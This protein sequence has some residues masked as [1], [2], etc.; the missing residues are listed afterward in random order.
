MLPASG[1]RL[2]S[3]GHEPRRLRAREHFLDT[4][5]YGY[6]QCDGYGAYASFVKSREE[7]I[8]LA[9][10]LAHARR[11]FFEAKEQAPQIAGF[12]LRQMQS[13]YA[14]EKELRESRA[15]PQ[16]R[17]AI[18]A[19]RS[20]PIMERLHRLAVRLE[21]KRRFLPAS[22]MG[23]AIT[24]LLNQWQ[25]LCVFLNAGQIEIDNNLV[26]NA[27]RPTAI[28]K[29]NWLF[30]GQ[31]EAGERSA[32]IYTIIESCRRRGLDPYAYL[33]DVFT[34]LPSMTNWQIKDITPAAWLREQERSSQL[35]AA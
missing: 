35:Q 34:R 28:G 5:F 7:K 27:I 26:E 18:R 20:R 6:L 4:D 17:A 22:L 12:I 3:L 24:Y 32:I 19:A 1:R 16:L 2:F 25:Q 15:G 11:N 21:H 23:Q 10:C 13:L 31:A 8:T 9:G 30:I 29:K 33:R 14:V